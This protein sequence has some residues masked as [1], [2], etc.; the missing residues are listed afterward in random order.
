M[1]TC[2]QH[3]LLLLMFASC[4]AT[5]QDIPILQ[6][7]TDDVPVD[8]V[9]ETIAIESSEETDAAIRDRL[10]DIYASIDGL[11][12]VAP[13]V[14]S[15]VVTLSGGVARNALID[16]ARQIA[17]RVDGVVAVDNRIEL[18][19]Q[20]DQRLG[21]AMERLT[22]G[23][24]DF[25]S[26]LP[27]IVVALLIVF[28]SWLLARFV[29]ARESLFNHLAPN[30][31]IRDLLRQVVK[32]II[33]IAGIIFALEILD[34]TALLGSIAGALGI[35]GLAIGFATR[36]TVENYI[37]SIL[38][39]V[40]Q[41][42]S[43]QD[44]VM[45][46]DQE[47]IVMRLSSRATI[48]MSMDGNH[49]R[50]PNSSVYKAKITNYTQNPRRR[51]EFKVGVDTDLDL[52]VPRQIALE[53]LK[54]M[55]GVV[56]DPPPQCLVDKLGDSSV[57]LLMLGWVDQRHADFVKVRSE[58]LRLVKEAFDDAD[59]VMPEPIY[60]VNVRRSEKRKSPPSARA[61]KTGAPE[62]AVEIAPDQAIAK[63]IAMDEATQSEENLLDH[64]APEE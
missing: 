26:L 23:F 48:L 55:P 32:A 11:G 63:Q 34:A 25:V 38:L 27:S 46:D 17:A 18:N 29:A 24:F 35:V 5:A 50:I 51:F 56:D 53:C 10:R 13:G 37:A 7:Q 14:K 44:H 12:D 39:S 2:L 36:D 49:I 16:E 45:V 57:V 9:D 31:F 43:P 40:R 60:N 52:A 30:F 15:G 3:M 19:R 8:V 4:V 28:L 59:I 6:G 58:A 41:P 42:F 54:T 33:V 47:G 20:V 21:I 64:S 61:G 22:S 62:V 1:N